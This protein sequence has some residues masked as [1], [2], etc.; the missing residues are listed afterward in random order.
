MTFLPIVLRELRV[1]ARRRSNLWSRWGVALA[2]RFSLTVAGGWSMGM[3]L[4]HLL[5]P[6]ATLVT[7]LFLI[8]WAKRRLHQELVQGAGLHPPRSWRERGTA[9][10]AGIRRVRH[11]NPP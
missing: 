1:Q 10:Q 9:L 3:M 4:V 11:W 6:V 8:R 5:L 2:G 7:Y